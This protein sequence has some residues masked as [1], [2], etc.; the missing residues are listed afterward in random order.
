M[1]KF[2]NFLIL[3]LTILCLLTSCNNAKSYKSQY[4]LPAS[5]KLYAE[6]GELVKN[7]DYEYDKHGFSLSVSGYGMWG[8]TKAEP[9]KATATVDYDSKTDIAKLQ[10]GSDDS[11]LEYHYDKDGRLIG[12][13]SGDG[14]LYK[15]DGKALEKS[16][17]WLDENGEV[18]DEINLDGIDCTISQD[19]NSFDF[20]EGNNGIDALS[21]LW[22]NGEK[23]DG[24]VITKTFYENGNKAEEVVWIPVESIGFWQNIW[25]DWD[26]TLGN[27]APTLETIFLG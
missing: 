14:E 21:Y 4:W 22:K 10:F 23:K 12:R 8:I 27:D 24:K 16:H 5:Y 18:L 2:F 25:F 17:I 20:K 6:N 26:Y 15:C 1:K 11:I 3:S 9:L 19:G 7:L 13:K